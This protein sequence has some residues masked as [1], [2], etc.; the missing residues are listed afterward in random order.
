MGW[1]LDPSCPTADQVRGVRGVRD[2]WPAAQGTRRVAHTIQHHHV[3]T[4]AVCSALMVPLPPSHAVPGR[5]A[6]AAMRSS[7][8]VSV[9]ASVD[10]ATCH[11]VLKSF[12]VVAGVLFVAVCGAKC[13]IET[14][15]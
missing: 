9:V 13:H 5:S 12:E 7:R 10:A 6:C 14:S 11:L 1:A 15:P 2:V 8:F 4:F 3:Q